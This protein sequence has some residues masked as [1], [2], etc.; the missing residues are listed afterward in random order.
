MKVFLRNNE[1]S[2]FVACHLRWIS[3]SE[4]F[5]VKSDSALGAMHSSI[6]DLFFVDPFYTHILQREDED[7]IKHRINQRSPIIAEE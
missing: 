4:V 3:E 6:T 7:G 2:V 1:V 5:P